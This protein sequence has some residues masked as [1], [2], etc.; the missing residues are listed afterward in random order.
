MPSAPAGRIRPE[1]PPTR[2]ELL[3]ELGRRIGRF[4]RATARV[5]RAPGRVNLIG[6]HTDYNEGLVLPFA[7]DLEIRIASAPTDD[8]TVEI[9]R[10]DTGETAAF[11]LDAIGE[12]RNHWIDYVA[13]TAWSLQEAGIPLRGAR[14]VI[15]STLPPSS[16]LSSSAALELA[17]AWT[18]ARDPEAVDGLRMAQLCQRAENEYVGVQCGLMDQFASAMGRPGAAV[19]LDC[20]SLEWRAVPLPLERASLVVVHSGSSRTLDGSAYNARRAQCEEAARVIARRHPQVRALRDVT[21]AM[22]EEAS[23]ELGAE[24]A[25]RCRHVITENARVLA[26]VEALDRGDLDA[27]GRLLVESHASLRDDFEVSSADLDALVEIATS[28]PGVFGAR[29]TGAGF[30]GCIVAL[31]RPDAADALGA[32]VRRDYPARSGLEPR[33]WAVS[34]VAGAGWLA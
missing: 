14:A 22:L 33:V 9:T 17:S 6:E 32:A 13:G 25:R 30:G 19:L 7:I 29:M 8:R 12:R 4:D 5:L 10:L 20:R 28:V 21:L 3:G 27:V 23:G 34:P 16:G 24:T 31:V 11:A 26:T 18:L 2:D 1:P 15:A